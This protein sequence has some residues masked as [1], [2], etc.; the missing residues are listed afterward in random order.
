MPTIDFSWIVMLR[1]D[2]LQTCTRADIVL[3]H[4]FVTIL[5]TIKERQ[6][7]SW[8]MYLIVSTVAFFGSIST[9][10]CV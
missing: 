6:I 3:M 10:I 9:N 2:E 1:S 7:S 8:D 5:A 4:Q